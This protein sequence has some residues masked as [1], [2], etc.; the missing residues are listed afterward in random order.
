[1][2]ED[3]EIDNKFSNYYMFSSDDGINMQIR[4]FNSDKLVVAYQ[5]NSLFNYDCGSGSLGKSKNMCQSL[6]RDGNYNY[7]WTLT[8]FYNSGTC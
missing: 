4:R 3:K 6:M 1:M 5:D 8:R 2:Y 7:Q